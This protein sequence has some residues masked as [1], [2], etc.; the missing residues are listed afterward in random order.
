MAASMKTMWFFEEKTLLVLHVTLWLTQ[1]KPDEIATT[2][3]KNVRSPDCQVSKASQYIKRVKRSAPCN[4]N[5][6]FYPF[7]FNK[8]K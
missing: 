2:S 7:L 4:F 1:S 5:G 3:E 8:L 6:N